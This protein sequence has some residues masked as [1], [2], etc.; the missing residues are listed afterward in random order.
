MLKQSKNPALAA[1]FLKWLNSDPASI[2]VFLAS[3][4]FP[5]TTADLESPEFLAKAP[6]YFGGQKINEVLVDAS[7]NVPSGWQYLPYQVFANSIFGD[8]VGQSYAD[9][10]DLNEG[11]A[12]WQEKLVDYGNDQGFSVNK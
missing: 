7:K 8:T 9:A 6:E 5:A 1:A 3:G 12:T 2:E 11:L 4:G 10:G